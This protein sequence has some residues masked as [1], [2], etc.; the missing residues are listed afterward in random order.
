M[1]H[2]PNNSFKDN[3]VV[4]KIFAAL[5]K[6]FDAARHDEVNDDHFVSVDTRMKHFMKKW[7]SESMQRC[8]DSI[9]D[10]EQVIT[11]SSVASLFSGTLWRGSPVLVHPKRVL[12]LWEAAADDVAVRQRGSPADVQFMGAGAPEEQ[13]P[14]ISRRAGGEQ[15]RSCIIKPVN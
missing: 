8:W 15:D 5:R 1:W 6:T 7:I 9:A 4:K 14:P 2:V 12:P 10:P 13:A 3:D 11:E